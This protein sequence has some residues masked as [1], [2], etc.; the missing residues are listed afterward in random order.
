MATGK[1]NCVDMGLRRY[2]KMSLNFNVKD[3]L[4]DKS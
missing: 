4:S 1:D 3:I 2:I